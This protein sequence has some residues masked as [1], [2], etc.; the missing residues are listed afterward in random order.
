MAAELLAQRPHVTI[1]ELANERDA[2]IAALNDLCGP[3]EGAALRS[4]T[5][6]IGLFAEFVSAIGLN[7]FSDARD[8]RS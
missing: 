3:L 6:A 5:L 4:W 7:P 8:D 1:N 2:L